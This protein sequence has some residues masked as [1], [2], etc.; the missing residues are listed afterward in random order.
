MRSSV[1]QKGQKDSSM[2]WSPPGQPR[3]RPV[4]TR[5]FRPWLE[6]RARMPSPAGVRA[7]VWCPS[8]R[9]PPPAGFRG[10]NANCTCGRGP[11]FARCYPV[12]LWV[13][14][15]TSRLA[16]GNPSVRMSERER[17]FCHDPRGKCT[18]ASYKTQKTRGLDP[19]R[20]GTV[21]IVS[22]AYRQ[23]DCATLASVLSLI[24]SQP[25]SQLLWT[26]QVEANRA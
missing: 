1:A 17:A 22:P 2:V 20:V 24:A 11:T 15:T 8:S 19:L 3:R 13:S 14:N 5:P 25:I 23:D 10:R 18:P 4:S 21:L 26:S 6:G 9:R 7:T 12:L 16:S